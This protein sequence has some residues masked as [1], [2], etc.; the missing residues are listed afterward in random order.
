[1]SNCFIS[2]VK[3]CTT[4]RFRIS[5]CEINILQRLFDSDDFYMKIFNVEE[6][7]MELE[8]IE[9]SSDKPIK[10]ERVDLSTLDSD[11]IKK[12]YEPY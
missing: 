1:M 3:F 11:D 12:L 2:T 6:N 8:I 5:D 10:V 7:A 4:R 9:V